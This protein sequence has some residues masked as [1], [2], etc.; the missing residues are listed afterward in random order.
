MSRFRQGALIAICFAG[1]T[2]FIGPIFAQIAGTGAIAGV[3]TDP[4]GAVVT[5]A[6]VTVNNISTGEQHRTVSGAEG[7][8]RV[9]LLAPGIYDITV[10]KSGFKIGVSHNVTVAVT[11]VA[12]VD[13]GLEVGSPQ[14]R[15]DVLGNTAL[16]QTET[17]SEG[18][19]TNA[20]TVSGLPLVTRNFTQ[21]LALS[22]GITA[23]VTD[24]GQLGRGGN[25][26]Q[27]GEGNAHAHGS[28]ALDNN[29]QING[30]QINGLLSGFSGNIAVPNPDAIQEFKVQTSLYDAS[31]AGQTLT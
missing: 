8:Y 26:G 11:E 2:S 30:I 20:D 19:A 6:G 28:L 27:A 18:R 5:D 29:F 10:S 25:S 9:P 24:A 4:S 3:V 21:L 7:F 13:L 12:R 22:P 31:F 23:D 16:V 14:Q 1:L 15:L 17:S